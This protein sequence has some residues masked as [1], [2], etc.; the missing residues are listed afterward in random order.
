MTDEVTDSSN[1][2]QLGL[3]L[4]YTNDTTVAECSM[5]MLD[6]RVLKVCQYVTKLWK[7]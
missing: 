7:Y 2:K 6:V 3:I 1:V 4:R 5:N